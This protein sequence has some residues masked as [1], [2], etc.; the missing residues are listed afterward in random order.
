MSPAYIGF[1]RVLFGG[2][3]YFDFTHKKN[4]MNLN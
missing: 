1:L 3:I 4:I 2:L